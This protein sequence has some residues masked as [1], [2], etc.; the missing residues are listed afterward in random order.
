LADPIS[1]GSDGRPA[2]TLPRRI[3]PNTSQHPEDRRKKKS[4]LTLGIT[5]LTLASELRLGNEG[6]GA[7]A[8]FSCAGRARADPEEKRRKTSLLCLFDGGGLV[9]VSAT[10]GFV[11]NERLVDAVASTLFIGRI[12]VDEDEPAKP[13]DAK[14]GDGKPEDK[15]LPG[16]EIEDEANAGKL[17]IGFGDH[18]GSRVSTDFW[19]GLLGASCEELVVPGPELPAKGSS[20]RRKF[21]GGDALR[22]LRE[23]V[24]FLGPGFEGNG[25]ESEERESALEGGGGGLEVLCERFGDKVNPNKRNEGMK[26]DWRERRFFAMDFGILITS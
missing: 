11:A 9:D 8:G 20:S 16:R 1:Q 19:D 23:E 13:G 14:P 24:N 4:S 22:G 25:S 6:R 7:S 18:I 26:K 2:P 21:G 3:L 10:S 5:T 15:M 17:W 12:V